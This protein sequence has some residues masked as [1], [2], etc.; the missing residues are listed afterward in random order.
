MLLKT[1]NKSK[2]H[3]LEI[4]LLILISFSP[5]LSNAMKAGFALLIVLINYKVLTNKINAKKFFLLLLFIGLFILSAIYD[6]RN[7][8]SISEYSILNLY[9]PICFIL[10]YLVSEKYSYFEFLTLLEKVVFVAAILSLFGV[11]IYTVF[12]NLIDYLPSYKYYHTSHKTA[13]IFNVILGYGGNVV[14]RN[15]GIAWEPGAFQFL[16]NIGLYSYLKTTKKTNLFKVAIYALAIITTQSTAG[17]IIFILLTW[18][19]FLTDKKARI[20]I[21]IS[22]LSFSA[23]IAEE[24]MYQYKYKLFGSYA[25][26]LRLAPLLN[27]INVGRNYLIGM[28]NSGYNAQLDSLN[29]GAWD[30]FGQIFIRYGYPMF[31]IITAVLIKIF[32]QDKMLFMIIF[33]TLLSQSIW[34][35][36][37]VTPFYFICYKKKSSIGNINVNQYQRKALKMQEEGGVD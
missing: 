13:Y 11:F 20:L 28:G 36:P 35:F 14:K 7:V 30:S 3:I 4:L 37:I 2:L 29:I 18:K 31:I 19:I 23:L 27:S 24:L 21:I 15:V 25:F 6:L 8:S 10:G 17:I 9:F 26:E 12:P 34:F 1:K 5:L 22:L 16:V 32:S 33:V